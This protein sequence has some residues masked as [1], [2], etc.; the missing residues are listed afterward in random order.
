LPK[1]LPI[2]LVRQA[3]SNPPAKYKKYLKAYSQVVEFSHF[4]SGLILIDNIF[5]PKAYSSI[6]GFTAKAHTHTLSDPQKQT[7]DDEEMEKC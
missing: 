1:I 3:T 4:P 6:W 2:Y 5:H 7:S